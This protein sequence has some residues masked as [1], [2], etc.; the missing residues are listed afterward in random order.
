MTRYVLPIFD[1]V[2]EIAGRSSQGGT[3]TSGLHEEISKE[4][5]DALES[6]ILAHA[7]AGTNIEGLNYI[8][9]VRTAV[10]AIGDRE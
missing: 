4:S 8:E 3:I 2:V 7:C 6:L 10:E 5:A 9:G 1:I